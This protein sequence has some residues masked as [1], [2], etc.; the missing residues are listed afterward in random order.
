MTTNTSPAPIGAD[1]LRHALEIAEAALADIGDAD[2]EPGDDVAWCEARAAE[3]LPTVRA[4]LASAAQQTH[5]PEILCDMVAQ[6][7]G[8]ASAYRTYAKRHSSQGKAQTDALFSTR[9]SDMDKAVER[10]RAALKSFANPAQPTARRWPPV[11]GVGRDAGHSRAVMVYL[12]DTPTDDELRA[13]HDAVRG[14][15]ELQDTIRR[16]DFKELAA[17]V[18]RGMAL[19]EN[20]AMYVQAGCT[21]RESQARGILRAHLFSTQPS[22][23][24]QL[25]PTV[26]PAPAPDMR[27]AYVG[28]REDLLIWKRRALVAERD[29]RTERATSSRLA[30][31]INALNGPT[32]LGEPAPQWQPIETA[33]K[34]RPILL[35]SKKGRIADGMWIAATDTTGGWAW[36]LVRQEP[37]HWMPI[38]PE[39]A[40]ARG[41]Q[42]ESK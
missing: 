21:L 16:L 29:L 2:R 17:W 33:P 39:Q 8:A 20:L 14:E 22:P 19:A 27:D 38:P 4:A 41:A 28:A 31:E 30:A 25:A 18:D 11:S 40:R 10:G 1:A 37:T 35:R 23:Q 7:A 9:L 42:G 5:V 32:H 13:L 3:A 36:A 34:D 15:A 12:A 24:A 6:L 26:Q